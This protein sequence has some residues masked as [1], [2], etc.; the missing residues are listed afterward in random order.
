MVHIIY[1]TVF[2]LQKTE[3]I[4]DQ[5]GKT[6]FRILGRTAIKKPPHLRMLNY[7]S[8]FLLFCQTFLCGFK[9]V[10]F[11]IS[12]IAELTFPISRNFSAILTCRDHR[13]RPQLQNQRY[14]L[15]QRK[16]RHAHDP[17][18]YTVS[19]DIHTIRRYAHNPAEK[20]SRYVQRTPNTRALTCGRVNLIPFG[21]TKLRMTEMPQIHQK[22]K[23]HNFISR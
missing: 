9:K 12:V 5:T 17:A 4:S 8:I 16:T 2:L 1:S 13:C 20:S 6:L 22:N 10:F 18:K 21:R 19:C 15:L 3:R 23:T 14:F 7:Y 11:L